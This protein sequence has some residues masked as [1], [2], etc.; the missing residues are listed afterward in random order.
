MPNLLLVYCN[1]LKSTI[2]YFILNST[3]GTTAAQQCQLC[4]K[5]QFCMILVCYSCEGL[6]D[7]N[8]FNN[9]TN[10]IYATFS[11]LLVSIFRGDAW[12][13]AVARQTLVG[14][15]AAAVRRRRYSTVCSDHFADSAYFCP[16]QRES[17]SLVHTAMPTLKLYQ[18]SVLTPQPQPRPLHERA[19]SFNSTFCGSGDSSFNVDSSGHGR[20]R[21]SRHLV[22]TWSPLCNRRCQQCLFLGDFGAMC[23]CVLFYR[24][25]ASRSDVRPRIHSVEIC[26]SAA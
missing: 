17:S 10:W 25:R 26:D 22:A 20:P 6:T 5:H 8:I 2:L 14:T 4:M 13:H 9:N 3:V 15:N 1:F 7:N 19:C 23:S 24:T 16:H 21:K 12:A 18:S 11:N